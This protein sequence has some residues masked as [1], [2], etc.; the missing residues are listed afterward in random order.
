MEIWTEDST[1]G[2]KLVKRI[3]DTVYERLFKVVPHKG[4]GMAMP[5]DKLKYGGILYHLR[6]INIDNKLIL[7]LVDK[8]IDQTETLVN[9]E[10]IIKEIRKHDNIYIIN[11]TCF[12]I[13]MLSYDKLFDIVGDN[14]MLSAIANEIVYLV[15]NRCNIFEASDELK[16]YITN[17][18]DKTLSDMISSYNW[19]R[20]AKRVLAEVTNTRTM[21]NHKPYMFGLISG[22]TLGE[23]WTQDC[24]FIKDYYNNIE[25]LNR[26]CTRDDFY[27]ESIENK[28]SALIYQSKW[29]FVF[30][31]IDSNSS[32]YISCYYKPAETGKDLEYKDLYCRHIING[33][34]QSKNISE[35]IEKNGYWNYERL[36]RSIGLK[37]D[38]M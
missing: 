8:M 14:K 15:S 10:Q 25:E 30:E 13:N 38:K 2:Y 17:D 32:E 11:Q 18:S 26:V 6:N 1:A 16:N 12:E 33:K 34:A 29:H 4:A 36:C 28:L 35:M 9:Y 24:C 31:Q 19:E 27:H 3:N 23:C 21:I 5:T 7:L 22:D 37:F 20:V